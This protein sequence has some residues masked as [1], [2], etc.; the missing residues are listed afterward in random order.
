MITSCP[1]GSDAMQPEKI[2]NT[3]ENEQIKSVTPK[4]SI[5]TGRQNHA[6]MN[7]AGKH[8]GSPTV[9]GAFWLCGEARMHH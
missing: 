5:K 9:C 8:A 2:S 1:S 6:N 7:I 3:H 4:S